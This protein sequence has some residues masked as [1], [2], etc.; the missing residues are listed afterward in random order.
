M[1]TNCLALT[2]ILLSTTALQPFTIHNPID[3]SIEQNLK[4]LEQS[5]DQLELLEVYDVLAG[6]YECSAS[7]H[8]SSILFHE[9]NRT[10]LE[11]VQCFKSNYLAIHV[12]NSL[13]KAEDYYQAATDAVSKLELDIDVEDV[14]E[15][16]QEYAL[17]IE[18]T[19]KARELAEKLSSRDEK[20]IKLGKRELSWEMQESSYCEDLEDLIANYMFHK[21]ILSAL[22]S[23]D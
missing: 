8:I 17:C 18:Y 10:Y 19:T 1:K 21:A 9:R 12:P 14:Q 4:R 23:R 6:L 13:E 5:L 22:Q 7:Q 3:Y 2:I 15:T 11:A 16:M 20:S